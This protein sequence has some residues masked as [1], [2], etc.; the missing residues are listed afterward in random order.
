MTSPFTISGLGGGNYGVK[1]RYDSN[2]T[3]VCVKSFSP[4]TITV[5]TP[6][7]T[8]TNVTTLATCSRGATIT[9][10]S[11]GGTPFYKYELWDELNTTKIRPVQNTGIFDNVIPGKYT[12]RGLDANG[13]GNTTPVSITV[14]PPP[15]PNPT[16]DSSSDLCYNAVNQATIKINVTSGTAPFSYS[17]DGGASQTSDTYTNVG[18]GIHIVEVIDRNS[19]KATTQNINIGN[20]LKVT[21]VLTKA[22]D[23]TTS[24]DAVMKITIDGGAKPLRYQVKKGSTIITSTDISIPNT[25]S[26]FTY[27]VTDTQIGTYSFTIIDANGCTTTTNNVVV[28]A[29]TSPKINSITQI[30]S[31]LCHGSST[32][33]IKVNLDTSKGIAPFTYSVKNTTTNTSYGNQLSGLTAGSYEVTV[34][35]SNFCA[36]KMN[37]IITEPDEIKVEYDH[38]DITCISDSGVSKGSVI[39]D[40]VIG[41][42]PVYNYFVTGVNGYN[43]SELNNTGTKSYKFDV[44]DFGLYQINVVDSNGCSVLIQDVKVASPPE[45][46]NIDVSTQTVN[47]STGGTAIVSVSKANAFSSN[48]P[49]YFAI[50]KP[51]LTYSVGDPAWQLADANKSTT[52]TG[53]IYFHCVR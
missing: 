44:V 11:T 41:G 45:D 1:V 16:L 32:A 13:C 35:D 8:T 29:K 53:K 2:A 18:P 22:L 43:N 14:V 7:V 17:L 27:S 24:P 39:I 23:C 25:D 21:A 46:L 9:A 15:K 19:C 42:I 37:P 20:E 38:K 50:Y 26:S 30:Q 12:V 28:S 36:D 5:P 34:T 3:G 52:F 4:I 47:C 31:I 49:F 10:N 33:A 40:K 51:G 6:L 48:G